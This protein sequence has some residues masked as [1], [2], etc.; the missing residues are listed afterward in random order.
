MVRMNS[1]RQAVGDASLFPPPPFSTIK[2]NV[3]LDYIIENFPV[4]RTDCCMLSCQFT[5]RNDCS[6]SLQAKILWPNPLFRLDYD[7]ETVKT[8]QF[9]L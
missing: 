9:E 3:P 2:I 5:A 4:C 7:F 8:A 6:T 1:I